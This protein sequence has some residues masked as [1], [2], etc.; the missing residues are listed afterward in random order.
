MYLSKF[1]FGFQLLFSDFIDL[2]IAWINEIRKNNWIAEWAFWVIVC[3]S[4]SIESLSS[5][6]MCSRTGSGDASAVIQAASE[7]PQGAEK[8]PIEAAQKQIMMVLQESLQLLLESSL[9]QCRGIICMHLAEWV[10]LPYI[11]WKLGIN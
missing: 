4:A 7:L 10:W 3:R 8:G 2:K 11:D 1:S 5:I 6:N 9:Q